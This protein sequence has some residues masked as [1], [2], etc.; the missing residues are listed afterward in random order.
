M[1]RNVALV[2]GASGVIGRALLEY[3]DE[4]KDWDITAICRRRPDFPTRARHLPLDLTDPKACEQLLS[5]AGPFTHVFYTALA[6]RPRTDEEIAV[7]L[8][9]Q[10]NLVEAVET[11]SS[12]LRHIQLMQGSKWY[13]SHLGP[14]VTPAREEQ[15]R[16]SAGHFYYDQH[17]WLTARQKGK[18]W[19]WSALR[20]HGVWGFAVGGQL[21]MMNTIAVYATL[22]KHLGEPLHFPGKPEAFDALYQ[23][24]EA[25]LFARGM[26]WAATAPAAANQAFNLT[27]GEF[28]RWRHAWPM[29]AEWFGMSVGDVVPMDLARIMADKEPMWAELCRAHD[30][31]PYRLADLVHWESAS[32]FIFNA[33]WD[34]MSSMTKARLAGWHEVVETYEMFRRQFSRL[35][36][37]RVIP[38]R[39]F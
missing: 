16:H 22:M 26:V 27:N 1:T 35:V 21:S 31:R 11:S 6:S 32:A 24:T 14:Y 8:A 15:P 23:C 10:R 25:A 34:Q 30:L 7:N 37:E 18:A 29:I 12:G 38:S 3:L 9:M 5:V 36:Q 4:Q 33:S 39:G 19:T 17:D 13:G 28:I 20:P 2:A